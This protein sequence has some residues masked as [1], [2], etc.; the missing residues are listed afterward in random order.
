MFMQLDFLF[1]VLVEVELRCSECKELC[2]DV[3][4]IRAS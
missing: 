4:L 3:R 2:V 1:L